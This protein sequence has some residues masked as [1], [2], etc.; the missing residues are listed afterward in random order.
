MSQITIQFTGVIEDIFPSETYGNFEKR[1]A[2][3]KEGEGKSAQVLSVEFWQ[4]DV[5]ILDDFRNGDKVLVFC[6]VRGK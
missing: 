1:I 2:W 4:G 5:N 3:I 6:Q